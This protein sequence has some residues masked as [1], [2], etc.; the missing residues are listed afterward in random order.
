[1][2]NTV[3]VI[4]SC[5]TR[6]LFFSKVIPDYKNF[7][8]LTTFQGRSTLI[9]LMQQ[10]YKYNKEDIKTENKIDMGFIETDFRKEGIKGLIKQPPDYLIIDILFDVIFGVILL[11]D[12]N[13]ISNNTWTFPKISFYNHLNDFR[14]INI[15]DNTKEYF[16]L[17]KINVNLFFELLQ[18]NC[19]NTKVI[20]NQVRHSTSYIDKDGV[21]DTNS[22]KKISVDNKYF[23][24]LENY[25]IDNFDVDI[26]YFGHDYL[27]DVSHMWGLAPHHYEKK[28]YMDKSNQLREIVFKNNLLNENITLK[29]TISDLKKENNILIRKNKILDDKKTFFQRQNVNLKRKVDYSNKKLISIKKF[30]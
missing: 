10:P 5:V 25:I 23:E 17:Y 2:V 6:D 28:Y 27:A 20:L 24:K 21:I 3:G 9:S 26:L 19:P 15:I 22:L 8:K 16:N 29:K 12:G 13:I 7:F 30:F 14:T 11:N 4:G 1:M 18:A